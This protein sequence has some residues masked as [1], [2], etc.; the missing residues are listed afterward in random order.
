MFRSALKLVAGLMLA[1]LAITPGLAAATDDPAAA[2][3][4]QAAP[5]TATPTPLLAAIE[6]V[7][8]EEHVRVNELAAR[9]NAVT[10][11]EEALALHRAIE[12]A[13]MDAQLRILGI[14]ADYARKEGRLDTAAELDAAIA[15]MGRVDV[16]SIVEERPVPSSAAAGR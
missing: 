16:P 2:S 8:Q 13:K 9:L 4:A 10:N 11:D 7:L 12:Q 14:Q 15:A 6:A 5:T 1:A 3:A